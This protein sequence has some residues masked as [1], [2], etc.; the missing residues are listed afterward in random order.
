M[1]LEVARDKE[2]VGGPNENH[3]GAVSEAARETCWESD[4]PEEP[5]DET[6][7]SESGGAILV[8]DAASEEQDT[9]DRAAAKADRQD[10]REAAK[11]DREAAKAQQ[12]RSRRRPPIETQLARW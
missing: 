8:P 5:A 11:A 7:A 10:A 2:A 9:A 12:G 1:R 3:G 4:E 6:G